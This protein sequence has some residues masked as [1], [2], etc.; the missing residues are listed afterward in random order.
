MKKLFISTPP[1]FSFKSTVYSHGWSELAPYEL[2]DENWILKY[3]VNFNGLNQ[4]PISMYES[5]DE[6]VIETELN[7]SVR[8]QEKVLRDVKHILRFDDNLSDFYELIRHEEDLKWIALKN[9]GRLIRSPTV[10]EDLIKTV[11]T[12]NCSWALTKI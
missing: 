11:C 7:L 1:N 4:I 10:F 5:N 6:I 9:A 3:V 12:T 2:D 8:E